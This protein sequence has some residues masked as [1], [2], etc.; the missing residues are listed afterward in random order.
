MSWMPRSGLDSVG[1][2]VWLPR[3]L[4]KARRV[5]ELGSHS[6]LFDGYCYGNNDFMDSIVL[7]FL[8]TNDEDVSAVVRAHPDDEAARILIERSRRTPE[9]CRKFSR[10]FT[11]SLRAFP[12]IDADE[13]RL[14]PSFKTAALQRFYNGVMMPIVYA[15]FRRAE[16]RRSSDAVSRA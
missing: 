10:L 4:E 8:R 1:G 13:R 11:R 2:V 9:E 14:P 15:I 5:E 7:R 6:R 16:R 3:L 12:I